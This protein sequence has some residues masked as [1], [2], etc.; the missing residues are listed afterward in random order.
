[1]ASTRHQREENVLDL[2]R[3]LQ[4]LTGVVVAGYAG[5]KTQELNDLR[6]KLRPAKGQCRVVKNTLAQR[7]L[8]SR[9]LKGLADFFEGP[10]ALVVQHGDAVASLKILMDFEKT[11]QTFKIRGG[12]VEGQIFRSAQLKVLASLPGKRELI[13]QVA[14]RLNSP[15]QGLHTVLRA[16][17]GQLAAALSEVARKKSAVAPAAS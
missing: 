6:A 4:E 9:G 17:L 16:P 15:I 3:D 12:Q 14:S 5:T 13:A 8:D 10:S 7:A 2:T 1:M 11:H